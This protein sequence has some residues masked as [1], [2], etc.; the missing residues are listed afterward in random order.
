[1]A[2]RTPES[3]TNVFSRVDQPAFEM[4]YEYM[5]TSPPYDAWLAARYD[6]ALDFAQDLRNAEDKMYAGVKPREAFVLTGLLF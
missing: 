6:L 2:Q 1:M 3:Q 5:E 4:K